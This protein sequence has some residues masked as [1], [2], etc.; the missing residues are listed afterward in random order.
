MFLY[1]FHSLG[2]C[3]YILL[4]DSR[5]DGIPSEISTSIVPPANVGS[6]NKGVKKQESVGAHGFNQPTGSYGYYYPG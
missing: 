2:W 4:Q 3:L 6:S 1:M 5:G